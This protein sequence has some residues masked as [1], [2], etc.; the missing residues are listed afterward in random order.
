MATLYCVALC[1]HICMHSTEPYNDYRLVCLT[2]FTTAFTV[3]GAVLVTAA[4]C[5]GSMA[6]LGSTA[7]LRFMSEIKTPGLVYRITGLDQ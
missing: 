6:A 3:F 5:A 1:I 7:E 2:L 4:C